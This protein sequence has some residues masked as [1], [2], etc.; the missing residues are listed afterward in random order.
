MCFRFQG[1]AAMTFE[2]RRLGRLQQAAVAAAVAVGYY[3]GVQIGIGLSFPPA[4]NTSMLW[5]PNAV[6]TAALLLLPVRYWWLCAAGALPVHVLLELAAGFPP[7]TVAGLFLTNSL[8]ALLA[9]GG[10]RDF[11]GRLT[12]FNTFRS[13]S[14]FIASAALVAPV[15]SSFADAAVMSLLQGQSYWDV[16]IVRSFSNSLTELS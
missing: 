16:W 5:P 9:A 11:G 15:L 12:A 13:V 2:E 7:R 4:T 8:G 14:V 1:V 6:L 10:V 3:V